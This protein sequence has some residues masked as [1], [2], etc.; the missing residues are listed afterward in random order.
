MPGSRRHAVVG[1]WV[2]HD[3]DNGGSLD[4]D[5]VQQMARALGHKL[6]E[7]DL[8]AAMDAM[9]GDGE[10]PPAARGYP[11][12]PGRSAPAVI[13]LRPRAQLTEFRLH[14]HSMSTACLLPSPSPPPTPF[15]GALGRARGGV[16]RRRG[17][18]ELHGV[19]HLVEHEQEQGRRPAAHRHLGG[20]G[21]R[22]LHDHALLAAWQTAA[23]VARRQAHR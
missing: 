13:L 19:L 15:G 21:A 17:R 6:S 7:K 4:R 14:F 5:E 8:K 10:S 3:V 9:D 22:R 2:Q 11:S 1:G 18:R 23:R 16:D 12:A 20:A